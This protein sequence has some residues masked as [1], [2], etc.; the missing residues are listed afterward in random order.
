MVSVITGDIINSKKVSPN[1]WMDPLKAALSKFGNSPKNWDIFRG[2]S[3]QVE[4]S[5]IS[6]AFWVTVYLKACIKTI[7]GLDVR[8]SIGIGHKTTDAGKISEANGTAFQFSGEQFELL[9]EEKQS[10][11]IKTKN[12]KTDDELNACIKLALIVMDKWTANSAEIIKLTIENPH[13]SQEELGKLIGI[14]QNTVSVRQKRAH[15]EELLLF[16]QMVFK[17]RISELEND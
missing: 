11:A 3:F 10:L 4:I 9:K 12:K 13:L 15:I 1:K 17:E 2:D 7:K 8:M 5:N 16:N 14:K 6:E